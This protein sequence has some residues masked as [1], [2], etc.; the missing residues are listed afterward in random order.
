MATAGLGWLEERIKASL[1]EGNREARI[2]AFGPLLGP[3]TAPQPSLSFSA[4]G[5]GCPSCHRL[6]FLPSYAVTT[7]WVRFLVLLSEPG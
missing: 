1:W 5:V 4:A 6:G 7:N 3:G 2:L